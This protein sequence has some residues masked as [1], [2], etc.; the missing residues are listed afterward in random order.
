[1]HSAQ[2]VFDLAVVGAGIVGLA[3]AVD[4]LDRG[5][6]TV[7]VE[8]DER[9]VGA[10]IRNFGHICLTPQDG[11]ALEYGWIARERWIRLGEK[12][13]FAVD[14]SGTVVVARTACELA[15]L[16][17]FAA[18]RGTEQ[19]VVLTGA[20]VRALLPFVTD[21]VVG[22]AHLPLDLRV[23]AAD[24]V[25]RLAG[26]LAD[27][28]VDIRFGHHVTGVGGGIVHSS[29]G[30]IAAQRI[31]HAAGHEIDRL[32]PEIAESVE[33]H[34]CKLHMLEVS[35]PTPITFGPGVLTG[36]ALSRYAGFATMPSAGAVRREFEQRHPEL[37]AV[38]MNLMCSQRPTGVIV[39]GDTH[40]YALTPSPFDDEDVAELLLREGARLFGA[41][42]T[43]RRR[44]HG[45]YAH[46]TVT[47]FLVA[48]P[49]PDV[50]VVSVT[51]GIGMTTAFGLAHRV[52]DQ[53]G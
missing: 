13:G 23:D 45:I 25:G 7:V 43:V 47:D 28:G 18:T 20:E 11:Q 22:G 5:L 15:V 34:R 3:H 51:S 33:L 46:S 24:A 2:P 4:A 26:W 48:A 37:L 53:L 12:V 41:P 36:Q 42:L 49:E 16:E 50:R 14:Q 35:P 32:F 27:S 1:M 6:G 17:E 9:A 52:L 31:V 29:H 8:Q 10:S 38:G 21:E 44:W 39:L 19:A 30:P 40:E